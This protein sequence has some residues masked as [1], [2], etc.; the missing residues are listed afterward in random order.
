[1][2]ALVYFRKIFEDSEVVRYEFGDDHDSFSRRLT[3]RKVPR[4]S[5]ADDGLVDYTF[6]KALRKINALHTER[7]QWPERGMSA[8]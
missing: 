3:M 8:S 2:A 5:V 1:M 6:L 7:G 4:T